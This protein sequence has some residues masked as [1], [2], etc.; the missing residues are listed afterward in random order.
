[1]MGKNKK[2]FQ[3]FKEY[4]W[5][6]VF[7]MIRNN[8]KDPRICTDNFRHKWVVI[9]GATSGIGYVTAKKYASRGANLL[10]INRNTQKS[11]AL[12]QEIEQEYGVSCAFRIADLSQLGDIRRVAEELKSL[13]TPIDVLIHNA[14]VYLTRREETPDGLEKVLV[15][16]YLSSFMINYLL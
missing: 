14:G 7:A 12:Q 2:F 5:S 10:C 4:E 15:V 3:Y 6:N 13:D 16:H 11:E 1:M 8:R 9:S